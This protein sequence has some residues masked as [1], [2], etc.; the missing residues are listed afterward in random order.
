MDLGPPFNLHLLQDMP[1]NISIQPTVSQLPVSDTN[2]GRLEP[3]LTLSIDSSINSAVSPDAAA[4]L[5]AK[6]LTSSATEQASAI[7]QITASIDEIA[8]KTK[9]NAEEA[10]SAASLVV[11]CCPGQLHNRLIDSLNQVC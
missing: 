6:L 7:E 10:N 9:E 4:L 11:P 3:A 1:S 2:I 5:A 8:D